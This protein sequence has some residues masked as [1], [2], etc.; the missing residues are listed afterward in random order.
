MLSSIDEKALS[1]MTALQVQRIG[2]RQVSTFFSFLLRLN[3]YWLYSFIPPIDV[4]VCS[5]YTHE[6]APPWFLAPICIYIVHTNCP[7]S[8]LHFL[9]FST[10]QAAET[11]ARPPAAQPLSDSFGCAWVSLC[12]ARLSGRCWRGCAE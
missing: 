7:A 12:D 9:R 3:F 10:A 4:V 2:E 8:A 11:A 6:E 5:K 1:T